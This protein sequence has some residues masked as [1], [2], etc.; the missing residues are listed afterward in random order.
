MKGQFVSAD[1]NTGLPELSISCRVRSQL[2]SADSP[3][4]CEDIYLFSFLRWKPMFMR[5]RF[6]FF[7]VV[8]F[9]FFLRKEQCLQKWS[10][11]FLSFS[12]P[13]AK[14]NGTPITTV[15]GRLYLLQ[16]V[17]FMK[18]FPGLQSLFTAPLV[19]CQF[20]EKAGHPCLSPW[21]EVGK[22]S[23]EV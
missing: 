6:F 12:W 16:T 11:T 2:K 20:W 21:A 18:P 5:P 7:V 17:W 14:A 4:N 3:A 15:R 22:K 8:D 19:T 9:F 23:R 10:C 1:I 13:S